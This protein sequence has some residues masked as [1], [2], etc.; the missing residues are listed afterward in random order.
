MPEDEVQDAMTVTGETM[1]TSDKPEGAKF[2][3]LF[4]VSPE[5]MLRIDQLVRAGSCNSPWGH[6]PDAELEVHLKHERLL[7][8]IAELKVRF[9]L[10]NI[11]IED[12]RKSLVELAEIFDSY[13]EEMRELP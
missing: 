9:E 13:D 3:G 1:D 4:D 10:A 11:A 8:E 5:E 12:V 2:R 6:E 7:N